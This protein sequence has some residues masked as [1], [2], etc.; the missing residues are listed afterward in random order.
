MRL[1]HQGQFEGRQKRISPHLVRGPQEPADTRVRQF[2]DGLL[3]V[4]RRPIVREGAW[5][6]LEAAP[7]WEGNWTNGCFIV[8]SWSAEDQERWVIAVNY[9]DH[10]SQC[11]V[12]LPFDELAGHPVQLKDLLSAASYE[13]SGDDLAGRGLYL[14]VPAWA[15]HAFGVSVVS[16]PMLEAAAGG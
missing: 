5:R 11:Y 16:L 6:Q 1:F 8:W 13:R 2:Y 4:L 15:C 12:R 14:D 10:P 9:S 7:A 3:E